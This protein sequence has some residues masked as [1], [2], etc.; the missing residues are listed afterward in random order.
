MIDLRF[1][2]RD[3][4]L[5][6]VQCQGCHQ[7]G[8]RQGW[9]YGEGVNVRRLVEGQARVVK[10]SQNRSQI[11]LDVLSLRLQGH[12]NQNSQWSGM[13]TISFSFVFHG[14]KVTLALNTKGFDTFRRFPWFYVVL[15]AKIIMERKNIMYTHT[16]IHTFK[17]HSF[18]VHKINTNP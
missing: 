18:H 11:R 10:H 6:S 2:H 8:W 12:N 4:S 15:E 14:S 1:V 5:S 3:W 16:H 17:I 9:S 7:A 13:V